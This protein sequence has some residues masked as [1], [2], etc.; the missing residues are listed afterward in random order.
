MKSTPMTGTSLS[1]VPSGK[2]TQTSSSG[3]TTWWLVTMYPPS[4]KMPLP[5]FDY[6]SISAIEG[7]TRA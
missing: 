7:E 3:H 2:T 6:V 1:S 5:S 4:I